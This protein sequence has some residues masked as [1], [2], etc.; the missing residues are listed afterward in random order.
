V[1]YTGTLIDG[2]VFDSS[3]ER[4]EP[5]LF[6]LNNLIPGFR[7]ALLLMPIGSKW[8]IFIPENLAYGANSQSPIPPFST[9]IFEVESIEILKKD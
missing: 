9:L 2:T 7:E 5:A 3:M 1:H 4:G 8:K 6:S